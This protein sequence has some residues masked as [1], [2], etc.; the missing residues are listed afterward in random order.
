M[1]HGTKTEAPVLPALLVTERRRWIS[2]W[3]QAVACAL[4]SGPVSAWP[5]L[6][7]LLIDEGVFEGPHQKE[8]FGEPG[9]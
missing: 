4:A 7:P 2:L 3:C 9:F 6:L 5:T 8:M 1:V